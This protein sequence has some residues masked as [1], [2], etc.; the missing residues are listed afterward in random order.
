MK[1]M[2]GFLTSAI[3]T[4]SLQA[5][6]NNL[7]TMPK[8]AKGPAIGSALPRHVQT[9]ADKKPSETRG[10]MTA[11]TAASTNA[12]FISKAPPDIRRYE[13]KYEIVSM[14]T[15]SLAE[16]RAIIGWEIKRKKR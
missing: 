8:F 16:R 6:T 4:G 5:E 3:L 9:A 12:V 13:P 14:T 10:A 7:P 1:T 11:R 2:L 15:E